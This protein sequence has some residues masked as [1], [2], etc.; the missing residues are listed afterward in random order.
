MKDGGVEKMVARFKRIIISAA[1]RD[2]KREGQPLIKQR[3][4]GVAVQERVRGMTVP[5]TFQSHLEKIVREFTGLGF[6]VRKFAYEYIF[7]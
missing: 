5:T 1:R 2:D 6:Q 3:F 7:S 4:S